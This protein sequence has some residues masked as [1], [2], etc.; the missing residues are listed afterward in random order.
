[1]IAITAKSPAWGGNLAAILKATNND[2]TRAINL[3]GL[4]IAGQLQTAIRDTQAPPNS[5]VTNLLKQ[6]FPTGDGLEFS[7]VLQAW[8]DVAAG[9]TGAAPGKPLVWSGKMLESVRSEV[10]D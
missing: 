3:L 4:H 7:D 8:K 1:M 10:T 9:E 6:R 2:G 5:P